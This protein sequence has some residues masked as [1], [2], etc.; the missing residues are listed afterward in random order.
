MCE[1]VEVAQMRKESNKVRMK[2][3]RAQ[4]VYDTAIA[5]FLLKVQCGPNYVSSIRHRL[6]Y[7]SSVI[8]MN[9]CEYVKDGVLNKYRRCSVDNKE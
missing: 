8:V 2:V 4:C 1:T 9:E 6:L 3:K 5:S 7:K